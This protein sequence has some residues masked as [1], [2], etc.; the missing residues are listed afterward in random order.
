M[1]KRIVLASAG[2]G[3]TYYIANSFSDD[4]RV[5]L[6][7]FTNQN[8]NNI[9]EEIKK[10]YLGNIPENVKISTFDSFVYN[11]LIRPF[12]PISIFPELRSKG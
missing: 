9:R 11:H 10:R 2:S 1:D 6:I 7:T 3:K 5:F 12:E 8:A 4:D